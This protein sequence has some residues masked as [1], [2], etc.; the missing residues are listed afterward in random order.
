MGTAFIGKGNLRVAPHDSGASFALRAFRDI[1]NT[2]EVTLAFTESEQTLPDYTNISGGTDASYKRIDTV[3][4]SI[5]PR[6]YT[7]DNLAMCFWG[8]T[9]AV[10]ATPVESEASIVRAGAFVPTA[11][12]IDTSVPIVVEKGA[13]TVDSG[14]YTVFP[15]GVQWKDGSFTTVDL[16]DEDAV[17]IDYTPLAATDIEALI[18]A[19]PEISVWFEGVNA[20]DE[21]YTVLHGYK[22]KV[23]VAQNISLVGDDFGTLA[24]TIT[25]ERDDTITAPGKS[26]YFKL[27][28]QD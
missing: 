21:K 14:D 25:L 22:G 6:H 28:A 10:A 16:A 27:L 7:P 11:K 8:G 17:T 20:I 19:A 18:S 26:K 15:S 2:S 5:A 23:G 12:L 3:T 1:E 4:L 9:A 13:T 24:L